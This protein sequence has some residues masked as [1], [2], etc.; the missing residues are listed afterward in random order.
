M[1]SPEIQSPATHASAQI[2]REIQQAISHAASYDKEKAAALNQPLR[3]YPGTFDQLQA[4]ALLYQRFQ[5]HTPRTKDMQDLYTETM[6]QRKA[7]PRYDQAI[8]IKT[9]I[10]KG[11]PIVL[12]EN[13]FPP[14]LPCD[15]YTLWYERDTEIKQLAEFLADKFR[16]MHI[17]RNERRYIL[18][19]SPNAIKSV[20]EINHLHIFAEHKDTKPIDTP[21]LFDFPLPK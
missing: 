6:D 12:A 1:R 11:E 20:P 9:E 18:K 4:A 7:D 13:D 16:E 2:A 8:F 21:L 14:D 10:M 15:H 5:A 19:E 3:F 17:G